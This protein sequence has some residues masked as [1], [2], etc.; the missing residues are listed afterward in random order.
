MLRS[1]LA[2]AAVLLLPLVASAHGMAM[3]VKVSGQTVSIA[4]FFDDDTP[5]AGAKVKVFNA[6]KGVILEGTTD[7]SGAWSFPNPPPGEYTVRAKTDDGHAAKAEFTISADPTPADASPT[8]P[9]PTRADFTGPR[10]LLMLGGGLVL[11]CALFAGWYWLGRR[12]RSP[13]S[14]VE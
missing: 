3:D 12:K 8:G 9:P 4:V 7:S 11:L 14:S 5:G 1:S 13:G 6:A 10:R 2:L